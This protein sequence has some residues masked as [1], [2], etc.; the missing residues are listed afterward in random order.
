MA[1]HIPEL[2]FLEAMDG[3]LR[4]YHSRTDD[5]VRLTPEQFGRLLYIANRGIRNLA[6]ATAFPSEMTVIN[7]APD[8]SQPAVPTGKYAV[9]TI[10]R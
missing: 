8:A 6:R 1:E 4:I 3:V 7:P 5:C 9:V 10:S 2:Q